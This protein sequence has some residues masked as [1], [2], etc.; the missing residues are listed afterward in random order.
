M[1]NV[2]FQV[3]DRLPGTEVRQMEDFLDPPGEN[4]DVGEPDLS[5]LTVSFSEEREGVDDSEL[6]SEEQ[7]EYIHEPPLDT[8]SRV[9]ANECMHRVLQFAQHQEGI[10]EREL[11]EIERM[12]HLFPRI[13]DQWKETKKGG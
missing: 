13:A 7:D 3:T 1:G 12:G 4:I 2:F 9:E 11:R 6:D 5:D 8:L 10:T